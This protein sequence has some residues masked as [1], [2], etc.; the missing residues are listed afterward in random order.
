MLALGP[1]VIPILR[2]STSY[3]PYLLINKKKAKM[4]KFLL[5]IVSFQGLVLLGGAVRVFPG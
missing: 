2:S 3:V 1:D 5:Y 4:F